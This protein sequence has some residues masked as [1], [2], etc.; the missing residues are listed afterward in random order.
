MFKV[1]VFCAVFFCGGFLSSLSASGPATYPEPEAGAWSL[2]N[3][4]N[5]PNARL[6]TR[7]Y[8]AGAVYVGVLEVLGEI[9]GLRVYLPLDQDRRR[10]IFLIANRELA[11]ASCRLEEDTGQDTIT[12]WFHCS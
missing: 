12:I 5:V 2:K 8:K 7:L 3:G 11:R 1:L 9:S 4:G 10:Q 6:I